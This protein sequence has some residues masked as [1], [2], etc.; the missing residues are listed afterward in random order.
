M[1]TDTSRRKDSIAR[2]GGLYSLC[3]AACRNVRSLFH[4]PAF[5]RF[6]EK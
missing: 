3:P 4:Q 6:I 1:A 2:P 5:N